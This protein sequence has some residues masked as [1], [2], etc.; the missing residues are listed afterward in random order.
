MTFTK[1]ATRHQ[2]A[3]QCA[4]CSDSL[5]CIIR[6]AGEKTAVLSQ[7]RTDPQL[8]GTQKGQQQGF[9]R[10]GGELLR[11][12][13]L[14]NCF[15]SV[16]SAVLHVFDDAVWLRITTGA[17]SRMMQSMAGR[18]DVRNS[19]LTKRLIMLRVTARAASRFATTTPSRACP[20]LLGRWYNAKC[21]VRKA[22]RKRKTDENSSVF[23]IRRCLP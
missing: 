4:V 11:C 1:P 9:H 12:V 16:A 17:D 15:N 7:Q 14:S 2:T 19:S 22:G 6:T 20:K 8:V 5:L 10:A 3:P 23:T 21:S 13:L 18:A